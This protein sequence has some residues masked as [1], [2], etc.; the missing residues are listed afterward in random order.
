MLYYIMIA[1]YI[2]YLTNIGA[3]VGHYKIKESTQQGCPFSWKH[4]YNTAI[5]QS[6]FI[7]YD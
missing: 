2:I 4:V 7:L 6:G 5:V 3:T 1:L